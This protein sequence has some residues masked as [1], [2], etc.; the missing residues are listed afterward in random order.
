MVESQALPAGSLLPLERRRRSCALAARAPRRHPRARPLLPQPASHRQAVAPV[1]SGGRGAAQLRVARQRA[2]APTAH[3]ARGRAGDIGSHR[4]RR[5]P[6]DRTRRLRPGIDAGAAA[7]RHLRAWA[8]RYVRLVLDRCGGN[9]REAARV[10]GISYHTL[11]VYLRQGDGL[12]TM[13][14]A[15]T[16][17]QRRHRPASPAR[18]TGV[19]DGIVRSIDRQRRGSSAQSGG[20]DRTEGIC[21][22]ARTAAAEWERRYAAEGN[23]LDRRRARAGG[24]SG[25]RRHTTGRLRQGPR[26]HRSTCP[27]RS[28]DG[29]EPESSPV[30]TPN[31]GWPSVVR[32]ARPCTKPSK[33]A[34]SASRHST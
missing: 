30:R 6:S 23:R 29:R 4:P 22:V 25:R 7:T 11:I 20:R 24:R 19:A 5:P 26:V 18:A 10:L 14:T 1:R 31:A 27:R 16:T 21:E 9:K 2:R 3:R 34:R 28:L 8:T 15:G 33:T 32:Q 13:P 12:T 17:S